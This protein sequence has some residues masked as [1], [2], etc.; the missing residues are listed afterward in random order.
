ML[1]SFSFSCTEIFPASFTLHEGVPAR[2]GVESRLS[3][4]IACSW[5]VAACTLLSTLYK[6]SKIIVSLEK[7]Q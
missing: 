2:E 7:S 4:P 3:K 6:V 5:L 1:F